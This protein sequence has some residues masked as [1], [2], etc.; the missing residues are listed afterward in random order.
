MKPTQTPS[1]CRICRIHAIHIMIA[2]HVS[3]AK[4]HVELA[5]FVTLPFGMEGA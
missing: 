5:T 1:G 2:A 3:K 4:D